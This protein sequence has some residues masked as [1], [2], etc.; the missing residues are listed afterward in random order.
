MDYMHL[1]HTG[2]HLYLLQETIYLI[3][4]SEVQSIL[5]QQ[6]DAEIFRGIFFFYKMIKKSFVECG[7]RSWWT[8]SECLVA[9]LRFSNHLNL[10]DFY[11]ILTLHLTAKQS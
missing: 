8:I 9:V 7:G 11:L 3:M 6:L 5:F 1:V 2:I 4:V 10:R